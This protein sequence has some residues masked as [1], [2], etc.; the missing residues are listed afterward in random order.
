MLAATAIVALND[1]KRVRTS[2]PLFPRICTS[3]I[4]AICVIR[5]LPA[6]LSRRLARRCQRRASLRLTLNTFP[7]YNE[8]YLYAR[9][10]GTEALMSLF[11]EQRIQ[12]YIDLKRPNVAA[13]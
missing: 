7:L 6:A 3:S 8:E 10:H 13:S 1:E 2:D 5:G 11:V 4:R 9:E 12:T